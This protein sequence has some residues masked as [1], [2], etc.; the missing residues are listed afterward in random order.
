MASLGLETPING[1]VFVIVSKDS[2]SEPSMQTDV[3]GV[4]FWGKDVFKMTSESARQDL[5][6]E[7]A[8]GYPID[9]SD[10]PAGEYFVQAL[11]N[12]HTT[13]LAKVTVTQ[14]LCMTILATVNGSGNPFV[15]MKARQRKSILI[16]K[17]KAVMLF[18]VIIMP[19]DSE[20]RSQF[21]EITQT[22]NG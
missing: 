1:R 19:V 8:T 18:T 14:F 16:L 9:L 6:R 21:R 4:P 13:S 22:Q 20:V 15:R 17:P 12:A 7:T 11:I 2:S 10:L 5:R 3:R